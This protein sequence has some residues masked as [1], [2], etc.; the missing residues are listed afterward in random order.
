MILY[1][2][3]Q[4]QKL[5][6]ALKQRRVVLLTGPRQCGKTTL[7][8]TICNDNIEYRTL[9]NRNLLEAARNDPAGFIKHSKSTL[10]IDEIQLAP[11]LLL[12]IKEHVDLDDQKGQFLLTGSSNINSIPSVRESLA[13]RITNIRLRSF[14]QGEIAGTEPN[15]LDLVFSG[16]L[17]MQQLTC[18]QDDV[19][20]RA[21]I[22]GFPE[23][24]QYSEKAKRNWHQDYITSILER[25]LKDIVNIR[26]KDSMRSLVA[27][28]AA[29]SSNFIDISAIG[30]DLAINRITLESYINALETLYL[31]ERVRPWTKTDYEIVGKKDK[32]FFSDTGLMSSILG[33]K[34]ELIRFDSD[35]IGKVV[36]T[37][38]FQE[39]AAQINYY[40]GEYELF[41]YRD[42][43]KREIDFIVERDDGMLALIEV[44]AGSAI[45]AKAFRHIKY[46]KAHIAPQRKIVGIVLYSGEHIISYGDNMWAVPISIFWT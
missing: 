1:R 39:L 15:F 4:N 16:K 9:D 24:I 46:F 19:I 3:W 20:S 40:M 29:W 32:I 28:L 31:I 21:L 5:L 33:W 25:D 8:R 14:T 27:I 23:V 35:R 44:K 11:E 18:S 36:E 38:I 42:K 43:Q 7:C 22:G 41:H 34:Q 37:F 30:A 13:G 12:A 6:H 2:R 10:I 26:R 17:Q 45:N